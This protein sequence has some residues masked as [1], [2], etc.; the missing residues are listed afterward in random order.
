MAA[1][2]WLTWENQ[3]RN[4]DLAKAFRIRLVKREYDRFWLPIRYFVCV[5]VTTR[6]LFLER[7]KL[8]VCQYPSLVLNLL[9]IAIRPFLRFRYVIDAHNVI[10]EDLG[11]SFLVRWM[12]ALCLTRADMV[13]VTNDWVASLLP[14]SKYRCAILP[15]A[16]P[17]IDEE[18]R[19]SWLS[20][21]T[22]DYITLIASF[23]S[24]EPIR[25]FITGYVSSGTDAVLYV[26]GNTAR[27]GELLDLASSRVIFTGYI[28][29]SDF[30]GLVAHSR[31]VV[32]LTTREGCLV[33]GGYE[34]LAAGV[35]I[36]LSDTN[37]LRDIFSG[38]AIFT[39][40]EVSAYSDA[41]NIACDTSHITKA[42][43]AEAREKY[44]IRWRE[45]FL[46]ANAC[47]DSKSTILTPEYRE[48]SE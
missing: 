29:D 2:M 36:I 8:V 39:R 43:V 28:S 12:V 42:N 44:M 19:P 3:N 46:T 21:D 40:N 5:L 32:D 4:D 10:L 25:E 30:A 24:D 35:P 45:L 14:V 48:P 41:I 20:E 9:V 13:L 37:V 34:A 33:R 7:P 1:K 22:G 11:R 17:E 47:F 38:A 18:P 31:C 16:L 6:D 23:S 15:D 27:A 26:T